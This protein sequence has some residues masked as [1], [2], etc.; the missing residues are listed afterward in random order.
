LTGPDTGNPRAG[1]VKVPSQGAGAYTAVRNPKRKTW[2][3]GK[4]ARRRLRAKGNCK[5]YVP[6]QFAIRMKLGIR[7]ERQTHVGV[8]ERTGG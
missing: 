4:E 2:R 7:Y 6:H 8:Y 3:G 5:Q 1:D